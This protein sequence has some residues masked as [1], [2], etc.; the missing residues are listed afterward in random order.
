MFQRH[1]TSREE[2]IVVRL[3]EQSYGVAGQNHSTFGATYT[4]VHEGEIK[5][6]TFERKRNRGGGAWYSGLLN[7]CFLMT[8]Q[9]TQSNMR[10]K[11]GT[12][13]GYLLNSCRIPHRVKVSRLWKDFLYVCT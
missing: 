2:V 3:H 11:S 4:K 12:F 13:P 6:K 5:C 7:S 8:G 1:Q 9:S 10:S